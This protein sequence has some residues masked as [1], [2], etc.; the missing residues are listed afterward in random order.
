MT[1]YY[2]VLLS[3]RKVVKAMDGSQH[4]QNYKKAE[5]EVSNAI[6]NVSRKR[7]RNRKDG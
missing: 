5:R 1:E 2:D 7:K 4:S 6:R 3:L